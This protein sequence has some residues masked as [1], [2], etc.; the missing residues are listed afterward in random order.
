MTNE[1]KT[2]QKGVFVVWGHH[3]D[4]LWRAGVDTQHNE[5]V[6]QPSEKD[7]VREYRKLHPELSPTKRLEHKRSR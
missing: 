5:I 6:P 2:Y 1:P 3:G 4:G 7:A